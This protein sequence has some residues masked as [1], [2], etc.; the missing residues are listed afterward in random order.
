MRGRVQ[1]LLLGRT[2]EKTKQRKEAEGLQS[3]QDDRAGRAEEVLCTAVSEAK[4][5]ALA[6]CRQYSGRRGDRDDHPHAQLR[7]RRHSE[8]KDFPGVSL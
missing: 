8:V 7:K 3:N 4:V 6:S 5:H 1:T 2:D